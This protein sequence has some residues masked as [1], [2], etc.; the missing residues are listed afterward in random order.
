[1]EDEV[2]FYKQVSDIKDTVRWINKNRDIY[3]FDA[4][5]VGIIGVSSGAHLAMMAAYSEK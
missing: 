1:M 4:E 3:N 2:I 5:N